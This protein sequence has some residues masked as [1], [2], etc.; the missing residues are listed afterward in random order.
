MSKKPHWTVTILDLSGSEPH[1]FLRVVRIGYV[2]NMVLARAEKSA[3]RDHVYL[4]DNI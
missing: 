2:L 1:Y 3:D 4:K